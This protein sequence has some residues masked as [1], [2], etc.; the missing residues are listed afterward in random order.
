M[1]FIAFLQTNY[2]EIK[3]THITLLVCSVSLFAA[4]GLAALGGAVWPLRAPVRYLSVCIDVMLLSA[5]LSLW[6][7]LGLNPARDLWLAS[8]LSLLLLYIVLG[9]LAIKRGRTLGHR[10]AA[11]LAAV[12]VLGYMVGVA[13]AHH[14][15]GWLA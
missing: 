8:K 14:P 6:A 7:L 15:L 3:L 10:A 4:R 11:L 2:A 12:L 5:G 13:R 1:S 9:S